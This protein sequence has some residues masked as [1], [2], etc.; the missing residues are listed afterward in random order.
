MAYG[1]G[2]AYPM[3]FDGAQQRAAMGP[4]PSDAYQGNY[5]KPFAAHASAATTNFT[6]GGGGF[7]GQSSGYQQQQSSGFQQQFGAQQAYGD[8]DPSVFESLPKELL[9]GAVS[10]EVRDPTLVS[11]R[12]VETQEHYFAAVPSSMFHSHDARDREA[13]RA[14]VNKV[15]SGDGV[16]VAGYRPVYMMEKVVE[17]P[18]VIT[19]E[20]DRYVP[21]PEV[22]ERLV[23]APKIEVR[24][25]V[26][27]L[28]P[29]VQYKEQIVEVPEVV[30]EERIIHVPKREVQERLI[31]VPKVTYVERIEYE[32]VI[33]YREVP[34]DKIVEVPE[35]E[36]R[37]KEVEHMVP[38]TYIQ[39]YFVDRYKEMPV[40]QVQEV[41]RIEQVPVSVGQQ[42]GMPPPGS[43]F[44]V[45]RGTYQPGHYG[46]DGSRQG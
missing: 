20:Y 18:H 3:Q 39:E 13:V 2:P 8:Y 34:V 15:A 32:D 31:E 7:Q 24:E 30:I 42:P 38:Q 6:S 46:F 22:I 1:G 12:V 5:P 21:K 17:V 28:P 10:F 40:T 44:L 4:G 26:Q 27:Q 16:A 45:P 14:V 41:Q 11:E 35:I 19:R 9:Q 29:R 23:E 37:V 25:R 36:Y 43:S 33:E